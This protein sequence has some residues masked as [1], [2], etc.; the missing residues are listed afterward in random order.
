MLSS[1][2][3][4]NGLSTFLLINPQFSW[5]YYS[6]IK[7]FF[8]V[9]LAIWVL[10]FCPTPVWSLRNIHMWFRPV[11]HPDFAAQSTIKKTYLPLKEVEKWRH[12]SLCLYHRGTALEL[13]IFLTIQWNC[14]GFIYSCRNAKWNRK[15]TSRIGFPLCSQTSYRSCVRER[16]EKGFS[17]TFRCLMLYYCPCLG[18]YYLHLNLKSKDC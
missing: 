10:R 1:T 8:W 7:A 13:N 12:K 14:F 6:V 9:Q 16:R 11:L 15:Q 3:K 2:T 17:L 18:W 4:V 5:V